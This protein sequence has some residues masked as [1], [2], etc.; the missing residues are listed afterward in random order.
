MSFRPLA[1]IVSVLFH[2]LLM[3][4]VLF[5]IMLFAI[6]ISI[7]TVLND[8]VKWLLLLVILLTTCVLPVISLVVMRLTAGISSFKLEEREERVLPFIFITVFYGICAYLMYT[9][10]DI[11]TTINAIFL[12]LAGLV[13][14]ATV[15]TVFWK[16]SVHAMGVGGVLGFLLSL[17]LKLPDNLFFWPVVIWIL[18]AGL[19]MSSRLYLNA[20][21]PAQVYGG[22]FFGLAFCF[23]G[24]F[25]LT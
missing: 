6:P 16:I 22:A 14:T 3:T 15:I 4:T 7:G 12:I 9:R 20:H 10:L 21:S 19:T 24:I 13:L 17:N 23:G 11:N 1:N 8:R 18:L 5:G 25:L 2:P